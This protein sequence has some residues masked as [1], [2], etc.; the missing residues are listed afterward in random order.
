MSLPVQEMVAS[1][2]MERAEC[3]LCGTCV[4]GCP[5]EAIRFSFTSGR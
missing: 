1:G 4:D 3:V 5:N 2:S